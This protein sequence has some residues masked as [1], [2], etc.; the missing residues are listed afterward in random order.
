MPKVIR[1]VFTCLMLLFSAL[2]SGAG[3][4]STAATPPSVSTAGFYI[5]QLIKARL[6]V[7]ESLKDFSVSEIAP[8]A[9]AVGRFNVTV[10]FQARSPFG[11]YTAHSASYQMKRASS[12]NVWIVTAQ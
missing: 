5:R 8:S 11:S 9:N 6:R 12:G 10:T 4:G 2:A 3:S 1:W 7:P